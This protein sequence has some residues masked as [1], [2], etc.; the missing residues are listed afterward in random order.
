MGR[1]VEL[2]I[3]QMKM[4]E[5]IFKKDGE[6]QNTIC[7]LFLFITLFA[8]FTGCVSNKIVTT[9]N[10][11]AG[12]EFVEEEIII[13]LEELNEDAIM[14]YEIQGEEN[15]YVSEKYLLEVQNKLSAK[16][17]GEIWIYKNEKNEEVKRKQ[18][19]IDFDKYW[20]KLSII[21]WTFVDGY[22]C[23]ERDKGY[24]LPIHDFKKKKKKPVLIYETEA[25]GN[26]CIE[27]KKGG[28][29]KVLWVEKN[30]FLKTRNGKI[31]TK[32]GKPI[33]LNKKVKIM[34]CLPQ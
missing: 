5:I 26:W 13:P 1:Q 11:I 31:L 27:N 17:D 9:E 34:S 32:K 23:E 8:F 6:D 24:L 21:I 12:I 2:N 7:V 3:R 19:E 4:K 25:K 29:C 22:T 16:I 28:S 14:A 20:P 10:G 30:R 33:V 15:I 18:K